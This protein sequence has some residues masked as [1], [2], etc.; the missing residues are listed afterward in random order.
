MTDDEQRNL[1]GVI[2]KL[3]R[4]KAAAASPRVPDFVPP[5]DTQD[6]LN[7]QLGEA[8]KI[9]RDLSDWVH[10]PTSD[11]VQAVHVGRALGSLMT[12]S[13]TLA[14]VAAELRN[15][16]TETRHRMIVEHS[17]E[18]RGSAKAENE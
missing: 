1:D 3:R 7:A 11:I 16:P 5:T 13:A 9:M 6:L 14:R 2:D 4:E 8:L 18:G 15:G 10:R 12:S 17:G